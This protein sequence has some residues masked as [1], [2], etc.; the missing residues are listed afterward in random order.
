[1]RFIDDSSACCNEKVNDDLVEMEE[2]YCSVN[3]D[4]PNFTDDDLIRAIDRVQ[5]FLDNRPLYLQICKNEFAALLLKALGPSKITS[6]IVS[7]LFNEIDVD[8]D[9]HLSVEEIANYMIKV[10]QQSKMEKFTFF[11]DRLVHASHLGTFAF[12]CASSISIAKNVFVRLY[13]DG[14]TFITLAHA[15]SVWLSF[16][17]GILYLVSVIYN[18]KALLHGTKL[19]YGTKLSNLAKFWQLASFFL[20][21]DQVSFYQRQNN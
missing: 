17:G 13:G 8:N 10:E 20:A 12:V 4:S 3:L 6:S 11:Y 19:S 5:S 1:M 21:I 18:A 16:I 2:N 15:L 14:Y 9:G 7:D